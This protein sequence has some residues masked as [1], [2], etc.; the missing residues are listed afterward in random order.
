MNK[1]KRARAF[2][3]FIVMIFPALA[4]LAI[5]GCG[6][7][8]PCATCGKHP[9]QSSSS[10]S[11]SRPLPS[12]S[13]TVATSGTFTDVRDGKDYRWVKIGTQTWM[14]ENLNYAASDS[15]C[16]GDDGKLKDE[17]TANCDKYKRLYNWATAMKVCPPNWHIPS[18]AEWDKLMR[19]V[20]GDSGTSSP[21]NSPTAG[22][23]LKAAG[24]WNGYNGKSGNGTDAHGFVA[25]PGGGYSGGS[26]G[27][28][29]YY[30]YWW[31]AS[32]SSTSYAY[33]RLMT[34]GYESARW[35]YGNKHFLFSVRCLRD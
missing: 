29:G 10:F 23:Y 32:E 14:A 28:A 26:F 2:F 18:N 27:S 8:K 25:L 33:G 6:G 35:G 19:H 15:K 20:D 22:K 4:A 1:V 16:G 30:G 11:H 31:S 9:E 34:Y 17:D 3:P 5:L 21:Y 13:S 24:S 7:S 12:S